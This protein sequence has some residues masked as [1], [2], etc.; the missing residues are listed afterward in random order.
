MCSTRTTVATLVVMYKFDAAQPA[1]LYLVPCCLV[2]SLGVAFARK[3][4]SALF[5]YS[6]EETEEEKA[7]KAAATTTATSKK[8]T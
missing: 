8:D 1:L 6:E 4:H 3:E 5:A 7:A 2:G